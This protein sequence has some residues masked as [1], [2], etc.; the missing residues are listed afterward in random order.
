M[1]LLTVSRL[2]YLTFFITSIPAL[3]QSNQ[4]VKNGERVDANGFP[5]THST[6]AEHVQTELFNKQAREGISTPTS[7]ASINKA[8]RGS[9]TS[10]YQKKQK[11][12]QDDLQKYQ[13]AQE[14]FA[15][16]IAVYN[17]LTNH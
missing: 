6:P 10:Q 7:E 1:I 15:N 4:P 5:T 9:A 3:A 11:Q 17:K 16:R 13:A 14:D 2:F 8:G 12:Y